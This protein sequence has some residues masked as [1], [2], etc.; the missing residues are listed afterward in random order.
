MPDASPI[1]AVDVGPLVSGG[2]G[3]AR[4]AEAIGAACR[5]V[6]FFYALGH[7]VDDG[8][9]R[10]LE[11]TSRRFFA[12]TIEE[13]LAIRMERGGRAWRGYFP[14]GGELTLG[15]P[16]EKEG[17][18][19]GAELAADDPRVLAGTP[20][21]GPNLFPDVPGMRRTVLAY[22]EEMTRLG[23]AL[24]EGI[25][26]GLGLA[27][28]YF[29]ERY[30][31]DPTILFRIFHY[32][33]LPLEDGESGPWS[34]GEHS[35]YGLL[36][37]LRQDATAGL[38]VKAR[39]GWRD[40]PPLEGSF[41]C[42]IGDMLDRMT[43]GLYRSTPHR[44]R[45]TSGRSRLSF[46]FFFDPSMQAEVRPIDPVRAGRDDGS[47]RWDGVGVHDFQGTYGEYLLRKVAKVFPGLGR[48]VL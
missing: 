16:D 17:L 21:C 45:N 25:A 34:V 38:Q 39:G 37:I 42:N 36:T 31:R 6:G 28:S 19:F 24:M 30:S 13:K 27:A 3:R 18:Y 1:P 14:P 2:P 35:D 26:L 41:V 12:L 11:E 48:E 40:A 10:Q 33:P 15:R 47:E 29:E 5:E 22:M 23:R 46:A 8:L 9:Q 44:V 43:G 7:G 20:L 4:A 32:P